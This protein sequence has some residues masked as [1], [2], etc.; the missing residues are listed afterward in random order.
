MHA[1]CSLQVVVGD[2]GG[3]GP[4]TRYPHLRGSSRL[5]TKGMSTFNFQLLG[6]EGELR[7]GEE[8]GRGV[9]KEENRCWGVK[10]RDES[11]DIT[12][13]VL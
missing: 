13:H 3:Y 12:V 9:G 7:R 8:L 5:R 6:G 4:V 1:C 2:M 11:F 10:D